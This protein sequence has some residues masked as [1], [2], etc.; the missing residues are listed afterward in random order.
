MTKQE[1]EKNK[2]NLSGADLYRADLHGANLRGANLRGADL[3]RADLRGANLDSADLGSRSIVPET[4]SFR[5]YKKLRG[6]VVALVE[7]PAD[8]ERVS[9]YVG[10]K[11]RASRVLVVEGSGFSVW[12]LKVYYAPGKEVTPDSYDPDP[13]VECSHGIHFF[14]TREEA[15]NY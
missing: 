5:G 9:S 3:Y 1:A 15:A 10:R 13:R 8:A 7:I 2:A 6:G 11:C 14:L 4:G 12:D